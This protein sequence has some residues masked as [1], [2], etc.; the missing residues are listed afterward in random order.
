[1]A[2]KYPPT[3]S[4]DM[5][6]FLETGWHLRP[7]DFSET[8]EALPDAHTILLDESLLRYRNIWKTLAD[9]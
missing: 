2:R 7:W 9:R 1:V 3:D 8:T 5:W 6:G 4:A